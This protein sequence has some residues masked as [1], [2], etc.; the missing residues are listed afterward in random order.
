MKRI[1]LEPKAKCEICTINMYEIEG[2]IQPQVFPCGIAQCP[3]ETENEQS[4][5]EVNPKKLLEKL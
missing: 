2:K 5:I 1:P 4:K 3:F